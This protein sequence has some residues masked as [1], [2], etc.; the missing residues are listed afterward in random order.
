MLSSKKSNPL[1]ANVYHQGLVSVSVPVTNRIHCQRKTLLVSLN[2]AGRL[3]VL[4]YKGATRGVEPAA[5]CNKHRA[6][7]IEAASSLALVSFMFPVSWRATVTTASK[8]LPITSTG[9]Q[10]DA[11]QASYTQ[12][13]RRNFRNSSPS[14]SK[15]QRST[16]RNVHPN[17]PLT[18]YTLHVRVRLRPRQSSSII[19]IQRREDESIADA[20]IAVGARPIDGQANEELVE[21][22]GEVRRPHVARP[23]S[24]SSHKL[25]LK[26]A[27]VPKSDIQIV[28]GATSKQKIVHLKSCHGDPFERMIAETLQ[29]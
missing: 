11:F 28:K 18:E 24:V 25:F 2:F 27:K 21:F 14:N 8:F 16:R 6:G 26:V 15:D 19:S 3:L 7:F 1:L 13:G 4:G 17:G 12:C 22:L 10:C 20:E 5:T 9:V 29:T 23:T